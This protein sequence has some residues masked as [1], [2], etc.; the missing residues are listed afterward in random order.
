[1]RTLEESRAFFHGDR[2]ALEAC[3]IAIDEVGDGEAKCSMPL[4]PLHLN[5]AGV[6][7]G[8]AVYTLCDT[9][10]A[11]AANAGGALTV[12]LGANI[13]YL[14]PG[15]G[16]RLFAVA[17]RLSEGRTTCLYRI[18]VTDEKGALV[19]FATVNGCRRAAPG[20]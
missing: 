6:A 12:S 4:T 2:F 3:G 20:A 8:G 17:R 1:M 10:F 19:A 14:R 5:A 15:T 11:V 16:G 9:A 13:T 7:Q 18:E